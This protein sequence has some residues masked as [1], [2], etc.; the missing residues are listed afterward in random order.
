MSAQALGLPSWLEQF[1]ASIADVSQDFGGIQDSTDDP[2]RVQQWGGYISLLNGEGSVR[3]GVSATEQGCLALAR[4][5]LAL[6]DDVMLPKRDVADALCEFLNIVA[7]NLKKRVQEQ[8]GALNI[9]LPVFLT[10][11]PRSSADQEAVV[12]AVLIGATP[13]ALTVIRFNHGARAG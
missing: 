11:P 8:T 6:E 10:E 12:K 13:V 2:A 3:L 4:G 9:G 5:V 1:G 7:G